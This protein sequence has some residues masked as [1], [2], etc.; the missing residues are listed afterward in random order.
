MAEWKAYTEEELK[1]IRENLKKAFD[2]DYIPVWNEIGELFKNK[3]I[4]LEVDD[5]L[6][7]HLPYGNDKFGLDKGWYRIKVTYIRSGVVFFKY[8]DTTKR[9]EDHA[10]IDSYFI[11]RAHLGNIRIKDVSINKKNIPL[12]KIEKG[13]DPFP[14][15]IL[16]TDG[17]TVISI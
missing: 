6:H 4:K 16:D 11:E 8:M 2:I 17:K 9:S 7:V 5:V 13:N 3:K 12:I 14:V 1:S 15:S 10:D